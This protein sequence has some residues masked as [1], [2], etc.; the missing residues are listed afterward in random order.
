MTREIPPLVYKRR[1][2]ELEARINEVFR[3]FSQT[4]ADEPVQE[5]KLQDA[6]TPGFAAECDPDEAEL[7]GAFVEDAI[8]EADAKDALKE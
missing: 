7:M 8:S 5:R 1:P 4:P 2:P 6:D 3:A